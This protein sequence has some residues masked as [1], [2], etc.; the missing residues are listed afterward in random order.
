[1]NAREIRWCLWAG[2]VIILD[3]VLPFGP[4]RENG[5]FAGAFLAWMTLTA[6]V[7]ASGFVATASW[8]GKNRQGNR[9]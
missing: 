5:T 4:L 2:I 3:I 1:M 6:A 9:S 7:V 8:S